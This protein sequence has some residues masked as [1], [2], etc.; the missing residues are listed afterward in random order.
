[1][2]LQSN[3]IDWTPPMASAIPVHA[4]CNSLPEGGYSPYLAYC[5]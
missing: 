1:M 2:T 4:R 3:P 5:S